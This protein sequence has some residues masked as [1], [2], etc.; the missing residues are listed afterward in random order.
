MSTIELAAVF[1]DRWL[2]AEMLLMR[3]GS[4]LA[5]ECGLRRGRPVWPWIDGANVLVRWSGER[6]PIPALDAIDGARVLEIVGFAGPAAE[7]IEEFGDVSDA[8]DAVYHFAVIAVGGGGAALTIDTT[9]IQTRVTVGGV[10]LG[11]LPNAPS[12]I[13]VRLLDGNV[14]R[15]TWTHSPQNEPVS[16]A[17]FDVYEASDVESFDW[18]A[19]NGEVEY[20]EGVTGYSWHGEALNGGDVRYYV[21]R[22]R[23]GGGVRSLIPRVGLSPAASYDAADAARTPVIQVPATPAAIEGLTLG[24]V[25]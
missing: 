6:E 8:S 11:P 24:A 18:A 20:V 13:A 21:V 25:A 19:P 15:V 2:A 7:A 12:E 3:G 17:T 14:P 1:A 22:A 5:I 16:P 9:R 10:L 4:A 23:S